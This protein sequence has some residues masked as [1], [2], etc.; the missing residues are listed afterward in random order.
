MANKV[1]R[2]AV[3][4]QYVTLEYAEKHPKT[5]VVEKVKPTTKSSKK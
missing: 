3:T 1:A 2:S 5:T 4:G